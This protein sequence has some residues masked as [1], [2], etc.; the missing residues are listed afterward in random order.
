M[1][2]DPK[3][4]A[5]T[6][7][8]NIDKAKDICLD[9]SGEKSR[10]DDEGEHS[11]FS[12]R[13]GIESCIG[14]A[15]TA[16]VVSSLLGVYVPSNRVSVNLKKGDELIVAQYSGPRL[17]E[18]ATTLPEGATIKWFLV[19]ITAEDY[20]WNLKREIL[21]LQESLIRPC[22]VDPAETIGAG[23]CSYGFRNEGY[24]CGKKGCPIHE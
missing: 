24:P 16:N 20:I 23:G 8:I 14:H 10:G 21:E 18:G 15:D 3:I 12:A 13:L 11:T 17:A 9:I 22:P 4:S 19:T 7:Q 2:N 6:E 1:I 5:H